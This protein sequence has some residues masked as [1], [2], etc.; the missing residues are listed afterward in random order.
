[1]T[2][3]LPCRRVHRWRVVEEGGK[4]A[5]ARGAPP[6]PYLPPRHGRTIWSSVSPHPLEPQALNSLSPPSAI[7]PSSSSTGGN[8]TDMYVLTAAVRE[9]GARP[10]ASRRGVV[11]AG[12]LLAI[13]VT[14]DTAHCRGAHPQRYDTASSPSHSRHTDRVVSKLWPQTP[15]L[16]QVEEWLFSLHDADSG[17][18][19][20][21]QRCG[22]RVAWGWCIGIYESLSGVNFSGCFHSPCI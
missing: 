7:K 12:S 6:R 11:L 15:A 20:A 22:E 4:D 21:R 10:Q 14:I 9:R 2:P 17:E 1:M 16:W 5:S 3:R 8:F 18:V 13:V 19:Q